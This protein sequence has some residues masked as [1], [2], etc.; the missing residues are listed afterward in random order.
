[1]HQDRRNTKSAVRRLVAY[2]CRLA[3]CNVHHIIPIS[4]RHLSYVQI[5]SRKDSRLS[6]ACSGHDIPLDPCS[7]LLLGRSDS[8]HRGIALRDYCA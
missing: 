4:A 8:E 3:K 6:L 2:F 7:R 5:G 1:M